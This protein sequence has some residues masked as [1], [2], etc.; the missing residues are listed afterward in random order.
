MFARR[1]A[2]YPSSLSCLVLFL[3]LF[4]FLLILNLASCGG[5]SDSS[6]NYSN[7]GYWKGEITDHFANTKNVFALFYEDEIMLAD[8]FDKGIITGKVAINGSQFSSSNAKLFDDDGFNP[9][10]IMID[11]VIETRATIRATITDDIG[12]KHI[13]SLNYER[14][15]EGPVDYSNL[16]GSWNY[17][18]P[19]GD[20]YTANIDEK[21]DFSLDMNGCNFSGKLTIPNNSQIIFL[22][23][24]K[25]SCGNSSPSA[26]YSSLGLYKNN[27]LIGI[28]T[29]DSY[30]ETA[31]MQ[32]I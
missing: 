13:L 23:E 8:K 25:V 28:Q 14:L 31:Y 5:G 27:S 12:E 19:F 17:D 29:D 1:F 11:G 6:D 15:S 32:K 7:N 9:R 10:N 20:N 16:S 2:K 26:V 30:A 24:N 18:F 21:G 22:I 4:L 3:F